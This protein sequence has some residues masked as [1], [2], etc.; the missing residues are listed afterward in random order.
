MNDMPLHIETS[1]KDDDYNENYIYIKKLLKKISKDSKLLLDNKSMISDIC[2]HCI[3]N[4]NHSKVM[5]HKNDSK[6]VIKESRLFDIIYNM[7]DS[8]YIDNSNNIIMFIENAIS[9]P[10]NVKTFSQLNHNLPLNIINS[11]SFYKYKFNNYYRNVYTM[12]RI[13]GTIL[14]TF[15]NNNNNPE[16]ILSCFLQC[17]YVVLYSNL[18]GLFHNDLKGNNIMV[19]DSTS[20]FEQNCLK[21]GSY[22]IKFRYKNTNIIKLVDYASSKKINNKIIPIEVYQIV[23]IFNYLL[24]DINFD[25]KE[26]ILDI[27][28]KFDIYND[29]LIKYK[30]PIWIRQCISLVTETR[31]KKLPKL[32]IHYENQLIYI[33]FEL[34]VI[35]KKYYPNI[36][37]NISI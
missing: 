4:S 18:E 16:N 8:N 30:F 27:I 3:Y 15:I 2:G 26:I 17:I 6:K 19:N 35:L 29:I 20:E 36:N 24:S 10:L 34:S 28:N 12:D 25:N 22:N 23:N 14:Q 7:K 32:N 37:I 1:F 31:F 9:E 11:Y 5:I 13:F 21:I 33:I